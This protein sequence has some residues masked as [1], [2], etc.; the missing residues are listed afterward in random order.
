MSDWV[1]F[2]IETLMYDSNHTDG[3][4]THGFAYYMKKLIEQN[5]KALDLLYDIKTAIEKIE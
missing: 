1:N 3:R 4:K 2:R 5:D